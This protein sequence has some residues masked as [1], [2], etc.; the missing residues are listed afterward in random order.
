MLENQ[1]RVA[2]LLLLSSACALHGPAAYRLSGVGRGAVLVPPGVTSANLVRRTTAVDVTPGPGACP[3]PAPPVALH[4]IKSRMRVTV[5]REALLHQAAGWLR[6]W[7]VAL[8]AQGCVAPGDGLKLA[9]AAAESVPVDAGAEFRLL[10]RVTL[11]GEIGSHT[12]IQVVTPILSP[13]AS[14]DAGIPNPTQ[15]T[16][17]GSHLNVAVRS[18][19]T[20]TGYETG[21]YAVEVRAG[22][23][24]FTIVPLSGE[25]RING[26]TQPEA[27]P[28]VDYFRFSDQ[29]AFYRLLYKADPSE[30]TALVVA[31][32]TPDELDRNTR[33]LEIGAVSCQKLN[34]GDC[35]AIPKTAAINLFLEVTVNGAAVHVPWGAPLSAAIRSGGEPQPANILP[36]L[37]I[38]KSYQGRLVPVQF[39]HSRP[40]ILQLTLVGGE[41][42]AWK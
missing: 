2:L 36:T 26:E 41:V 17:N 29:A 31:A 8:E 28:A 27:K 21:W 32:R 19:S 22:G 37:E 25:R 13:G 5:W 3:P 42:I 15:I 12:R 33:T 1:H 23:L 4:K 10:N 16:G 11:R 39:D 24:G 18:P 34:A 40:A 20:L 30:F 9:V 7:A 6:D 14:A 35:V 38:R